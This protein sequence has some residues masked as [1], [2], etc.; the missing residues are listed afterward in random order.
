MGNRQEHLSFLLLVTQIR[1]KNHL[2]YRR[3]WPCFRIR[4]GIQ[5]ELHSKL[6]EGSLL[7][8]PKLV[9]DCAFLNT[10]VSFY[11]LSFFHL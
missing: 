8:E 5:I 7:F 6:L 3:S 11:T 2:T 9:Y 10:T 4:A 1:G